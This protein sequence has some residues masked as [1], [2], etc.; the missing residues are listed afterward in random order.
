VGEHHAHILG[1]Y[2][3][4]AAIETFIDQGK[5]RKGS[6]ASPDLAA[7]AGRR[8]VFANEPEEDRNSPTG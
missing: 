4:A 1:D 3:W 5:Y 7:L 8:M 2:A 6:D